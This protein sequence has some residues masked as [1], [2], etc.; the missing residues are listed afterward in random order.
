MSRKK[1]ENTEDR[2]PVCYRLPSLLHKLVS[3]E[4]A[5]RGIGKGDL[6]ELAIR[7]YLR[8]PRKRAA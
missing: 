6:V 3:V 4:A 7:R 8:V 5:Q 1:K 2:V